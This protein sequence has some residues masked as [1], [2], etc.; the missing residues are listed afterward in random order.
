MFRGHHGQ[1][2]RIV[3]NLFGISFGLAGLAEAW[4]AGVK[5]L[6]TP[7]GIPDA[8]NILATMVWLS[9]T[10]FYV[11]QGPKRVLADLRDPVLAPFVSV[12]AITGMLLASALSP[13]TFEISRILVGAFLTVTILVGGWLTGQWILG[14]TAEVSFHPGYFL[15]TVAGGF[16]GAFCSAQV[17]LHAVGEASFGVGIICWVLLGSILL[18]RLF[19]RPGLPVPLVPTLAIELAPPAVAGI[20]LFALNGPM[21][22]AFACALGGYTVLMALVQIRFLPLYAKLSFGPGFWAFTF[23]Y[24]AA[25]TDA[26][27]WLSVKRPEGSPVYAACILI[28]ISVLIGVIAMRTV[29]LLVRGQLF[30]TWSPPAARAA[31]ESAPTPPSEAIASVAAIVDR[32]SSEPVQ[33]GTRA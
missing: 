25:A 31:V 24:A 21:T 4:H 19:F 12:S 3:P 14:D 28:A 22:G 20:A 15:P 2:L 17:H 27:L 32:G 5:P 29:L 30:P 13:F 23:A 8:I 1:R 33:G 10:F 6:G 16:V 26:L 18:N 7:S 9:L 11:T